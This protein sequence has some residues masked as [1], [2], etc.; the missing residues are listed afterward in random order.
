[1]GSFFCEVSEIL[2]IQNSSER[3]YC[4]KSIAVG[5]CSY[6]LSLTWAFAA[7]HMFSIAL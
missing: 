7:S 1:M 4:E 2:K 6:R 3:H 5:K